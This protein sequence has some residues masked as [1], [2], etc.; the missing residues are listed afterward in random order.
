MV[1]K[2]FLLALF[3]SV[4][5]LLVEVLDSLLG[6]FEGSLGLSN[7]GVKTGKFNLSVSKGDLSNLDV[8]G[9]EVSSLLVGLNS[10]VLSES[11][12]VEGVLDLF[13]ELVAKGDDSLDTT[14]VS[15]LLD[16][17]GD[18]G[19]GLEDLGPALSVLE[20]GGSLG[21]VKKVL[22]DEGDSLLGKL[23]LRVDL[24][25]SLDEGILTGGGLKV[26]GEESSALGDDGGGVL[27]LTDLLFELG[28]LL[29]ALRVQLTEL[30]VQLGKLLLLLLNDDGDDLSLGVQLTL[31]LSLKLDADGVALSKV[32]IVSRDV[33]VAG[34][35]E[36]LVFTIVL[37]LLSDVSVFQLAKGGQQT[38]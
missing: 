16:S 13:E 22:L 29:L 5:S 37:L 7:L 12:E 8:N 32:L 34:L 25:G 36:V 18:G 1:V 38:V 30:G 4:T 33:S 3:I 28:G 2:S 11:L 26:V 15:D 27:V 9:N 17:G 19:E 21:S 35:L 20:L 14:L 6:V 10:L 31:Q 24:S 23:G